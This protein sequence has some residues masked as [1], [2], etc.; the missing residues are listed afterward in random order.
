LKTVRW[1][2]DLGNG[3]AINRSVLDAVEL[4]RAEPATHSRMLAILTDNRRLNY[5][6][7]DAQVI[8]AMARANVTLNAILTPDAESPKP[9]RGVVN[10]DF[11][12][13]NVFHLA[14]ETGGAVLQS[15]RTGESLIRL[16]TE[17]RSR[18]RL[19][20][21]PAPGDGLRRVRVELA[22]AARKK[23]PKA[24]LRAR[25]TYYAGAAEPLPSTPA[26]PQ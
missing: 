26:Q 25:G 2:A 8:E 5:Q 21:R 7:T 19:S 18:Y 13:S 10:P 17:L 4:L 23:F 3:T 9:E 6:I 1:S 15:G 20:Y 14:E 24:V 11:T 16:I 12:P 22:P